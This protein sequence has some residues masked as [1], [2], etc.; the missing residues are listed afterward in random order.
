MNSFL[1]EVSVNM[2]KIMKIQKKR[3]DST[4]ILMKKSLLGNA[5]RIEIQ[6]IP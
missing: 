1:K 5:I 6:R 4:R 3:G 2:E